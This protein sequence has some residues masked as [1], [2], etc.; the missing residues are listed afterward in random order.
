M[1]IFRARY[2]RDMASMRAENARLSRDLDAARTELDAVQ[3][4]AKT[5]ANAAPRRDTPAAEV[6]ERLIEGG[7]PHPASTPRRGCGTCRLLADRLAAL[8]V[9]HEADTRELHDLRQG[10]GS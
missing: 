7:H 5:A 6:G 2:E 4:A 9:S 3:A 10:A 8:Q 1:L